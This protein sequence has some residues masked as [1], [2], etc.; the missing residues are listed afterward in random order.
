MIRRP[1]RIIVDDDTSSN[2]LEI[3][4]ASVFT[5]NLWVGVWVSAGVRSDNTSCGKQKNFIVFCVHVLSKE[6]V[7][8]R[9]DDD[10]NRCSDHDKS[11]LVLTPQSH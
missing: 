3:D 4:G 6:R 8:F 5:W 2:R 11:I 9:L 1:N 10:T 7:S